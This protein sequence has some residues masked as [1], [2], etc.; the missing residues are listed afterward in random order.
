MLS[1]SVLTDSSFCIENKLNPQ[2]QNEE[3][4]LKLS[5]AISSTC[6]FILQKMLNNIVNML[7]TICRNISV[8]CQVTSYS[9]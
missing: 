2:K 7:G 1:R 5:L 4:V 8:F 3:K 6:T 9:N